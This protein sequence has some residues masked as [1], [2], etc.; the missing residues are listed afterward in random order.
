[1]HD[2]MKTIH[3]LTVVHLD[4]ELAAAVEAPGREIDGADDGPDSV[5]K[6]QFGVKLKPLESVHFDADI[7]QDPQAS[8]TLD[9]FL[10]L[11]LMRRTRQ[12]V[13]LYAAMVR[14]HQALDDHRVLVALV[15]HP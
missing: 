4:G 10:L 8:D 5:G 12:D 6:Q 3:D 9:E 2:G 7:V 15:L 11:Q 13:H 14:P 1:M